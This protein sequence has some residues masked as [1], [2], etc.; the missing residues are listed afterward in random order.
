MTRTFIIKK[1]IRR[2]SELLCLA[3]IITVLTA[4]LYTVMS[5]FSHRVLIREVIKS[6][7]RPILLTWFAYLLL[8]QNVKDYDKKSREETKMIRDVE[9]HFL[10]HCP[11]KAVSGD[12][13]CG[14]RPVWYVW[15]RTETGK[16]YRVTE[17]QNESRTLLIVHDLETRRLAGNFPYPSGSSRDKV[18]CAKEKVKEICG[19]AVYVVES[20]GNGNC[21]CPPM[22][23]VEFKAKDGSRYLETE[24]EDDEMRI[25]FI[26]D[27]QSGDVID[28]WTVEE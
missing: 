18:D 3:L 7:P 10:A 11:E 14:R 28:S 4:L 13:N 8:N 9:R 2:L 25:R 27:L 24:I 21:P 19:E 6:L 20:A 15:L 5:V 12:F 26:H 22:P 23:Y 16:E 17:I 1:I